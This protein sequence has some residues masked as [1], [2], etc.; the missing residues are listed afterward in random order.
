MNDIAKVVNYS[1]QKSDD[2]AYKDT[3]DQESCYIGIYHSNS[4]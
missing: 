2:F 1:L 4:W 3:K